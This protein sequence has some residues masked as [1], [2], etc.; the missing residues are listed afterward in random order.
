[1]TLLELPRRRAGPRVFLEPP[2]H[3]ERRVKRA[4]RALGEL[5]HELGDLPGLGALSAALIGLADALDG[6]PDLEPEPEDLP[7]FA[8]AAR[9]P[10]AGAK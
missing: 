2:P 10:R 4:L 7:L 1:M 9:D 6:A 8:F 3:L 5:P